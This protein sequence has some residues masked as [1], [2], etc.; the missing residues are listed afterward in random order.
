MNK[1]SVRLTLFVPIFFGIVLAILVSTLYH[2]RISG[3]TIQEQLEQNLRLEVNTLV[4]MF[5]RERSLKMDR[6]KT[7]LAVAH[8]VFHSMPL[9]EISAEKQMEVIHQITK[10]PI[11]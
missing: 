4:R 9:T 7:N 8:A 3:I 6:V 10:K 11:P 1:L 2:I 5:E